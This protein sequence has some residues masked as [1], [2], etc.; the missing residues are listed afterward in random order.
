MGDANGNE[1]RKPKRYDPVITRG[2]VITFVTVVLCVVT[3]W[4]T[5][6]DKIVSVYASQPENNRRDAEFRSEIRA[7]LKDI[8]DDMRQM[9]ESGSHVRWRDLP[10]SPYRENR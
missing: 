3:F 7:A 8:K 5:D 9:R 6:H 4:L 1:R 2:N 10:P